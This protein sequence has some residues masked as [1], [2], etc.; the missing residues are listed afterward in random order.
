MEIDRERER[1]GQNPFFAGERERKTEL[2]LRGSSPGL[3]QREREFSLPERAIFVRGRKREIGRAF[4]VRE[5]DREG[6]GAWGP[7]GVS[8][9]VLSFA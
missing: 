9:C 2:C 6:S 1:E 8:V 4:F 3:R 5:L 7:A